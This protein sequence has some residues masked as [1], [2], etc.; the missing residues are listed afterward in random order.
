ERARPAREGKGARR[1]NRGRRTQ[2]ARQ[3][4]DRRRSRRPQ[5]PRRGGAHP[6][7]R[8]DGSLRR[9]PGGSTTH[10]DGDVVR[11]VV[12]VERHL[13]AS[14][15]TFLRRVEATLFSPRGWLR[16]G[17]LAFRR[18]RRAPVDVR[19]VLASPAT[20]DRLC[21]PARTLGRLS[22]HNDG[23][24]VINAWRW[25]NGAPAYRR[26]SRY[27][28]YVVN[29]EVGHAL[30]HGHLTCSGTGAAPVMMQQTIGVDTCRAN[31]WPL[32]AEVGGG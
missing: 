29:H 27:R 15:S 24:V 3:R 25:K 19:I 7:R 2:P 5:R 11:F 12:E 26:L 18:A 28:T 16:S 20:T 14:R 8:P 4:D 30:G 1:W 13:R 9:L 23:L 32:R 31:P 17:D 6:S 21:A 10:G 22:C